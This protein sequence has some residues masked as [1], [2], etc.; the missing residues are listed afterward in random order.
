MKKQII[1]AIDRERD[2]QDRKWG[3]LSER[4]M[5]VG[6]WLLVMEAELDEAKEGFVKT[7]MDSPA[8]RELLQVVAVGIAC[9]E[10]HGVVERED[11]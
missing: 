2:H 5:S 11:W 10:Q 7:G 9:L 8:L 6:H 4:P 3:E 1:D